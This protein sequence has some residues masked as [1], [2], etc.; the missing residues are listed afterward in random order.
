[1]SFCQHQVLIF[2]KSLEIFTCGCHTHTHSHI[3][4]A[5]YYIIKFSG[6]K[7]TLDVRFVIRFEPIFV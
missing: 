5:H 4:L 2:E 1:M 7:N 3:W 6:E